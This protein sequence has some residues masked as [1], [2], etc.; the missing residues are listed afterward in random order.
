METFLIGIIL[1]F[2]LFMI[3]RINGSVRDK[4]TIFIVRFLFLCSCV[5]LVFSSK[6]ETTY[7]NYLQSQFLYL[8]DDS[9]SSK[10]S[11]NDKLLQERLSS[12]ES[13][14]DISS[15]SFSQGQISPLYS[16]SKQLK[17]YA[18]SKKY[19]AIFLQSDGLEIGDPL[20]VD[21]GMPVF[22]IANQVKHQKEIYARVAKGN[23]KFSKN[24]KVELSIQLVKNF[25][26]N[27]V[28]IVELLLD[29]KN[30]L[31]K[32]FDMRDKSSFVSFDFKSQ[33]VG[34]HKLT[35]KISSEGVQSQT[36]DYYI[37][38]VQQEKNILF[39]S[40]NLS[41]DSSFYLRALSQLDSVNI[42]THYVD[43]E[44]DAKPLKAVDLVCF[45]D[46]SSGDINLVT[47]LYSL[48]DTP[49]VIVLSDQK[50]IPDFNET[51]FK[52]LALIKSSRDQSTGDSPLFMNR[53]RFTPFR[54]FEHEAFQNDLIKS[55]NR[56]DRAKFKLDTPKDWETVLGFGVKSSNLPLIAIN[57]RMKQAHAI[58]FNTSL[59][60]LIFSPLFH[61]D[62]NRFF[63]KMVNNLFSWVLDFDRLKGLEVESSSQNSVVGDKFYLKI[64]GN[65]NVRVNLKDLDQGTYVFQQNGE[66]D[67]NGFLPKGNYSLD[68]LSSKDLIESKLFHVSIDPKE[69][70]EKEIDTKYLR[71]I[72]D[73]SG[74]KH[75]SSDVKD[76][77]GY[78][79]FQLKEKKLE[80]VRKEVDLQDNHYFLLFMIFLLCFEWIYRFQRRLV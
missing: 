71:N 41:K 9:L 43:F 23:H 31:T 4:I 5:L 6:F 15:K 38:V 25:S 30:I 29:E 60:Q 70:T 18:Q 75:L 34:L 46:L 7:R 57:R 48:K 1:S 74:G 17:S 28:G 22:T 66:M 73:L 21:L 50:A 33:N 54:L 13:V 56:L 59:S 44:K 20:R 27:A 14:L 11:V 78:I 37:E 40:K 76:L 53:D 65:Q 55:L 58:I 69:I 10:S 42:F 16:I 36:L 24:Q 45:Y 79:P 32:N 39:I 3:T 12:L 49:K 8:T 19:K 62:Q 51:T 26:S 64:R 67:W 47:Q 77:S 72:S 80:L 2:Y 52:D 35:F 63:K 61:K 68:I